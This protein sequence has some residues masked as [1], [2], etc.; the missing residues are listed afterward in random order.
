MKTHSCGAIL[1]TIYEGNVCIVLGMEKGDWFPFKGTKERGETTMQ[2][3]IREINEETCDSVK[4]TYIDLQCNFST[5]R[6]HYHIGLTQ[7]TS[8]E[9]DKFYTNR[10]IMM[11]K[12]NTPE[13]KFAYLEKNEIKRFPINNISDN[14]FHEITLI[15]IRFYYKYLNKLQKEISNVSKTHDM[16]CIIEQ[17]DYK[18]NDQYKTILYKKYNTHNS[19]YKYQINNKYIN[20]PRPFRNIFNNTN[21][22]N[23]YTKCNIK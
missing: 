11:K 5:K 1:Y 7:I 17:I 16:P 23:V 12:Y 20:S 21:V 2:A 6:K 19:Q 4:I 8:E 15:P 22:N 13:Y 10:E 9:F 3:A 18:K 14:K